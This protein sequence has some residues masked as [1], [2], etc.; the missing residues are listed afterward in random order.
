MIIR[1]AVEANLVQ[2]DT[3]AEHLGPYALRYGVRRAGDGEALLEKLL[4]E[5]GISTA[6]LAHRPAPPRV[7]NALALLQHSP[8]ALA[9]LSRRNADVDATLHA[10]AALTATQNNVLAAGLKPLLDA[11][12][13]RQNIAAAV[14]GSNLLKTLE[15]LENQGQPA[16]DALARQIALQG[17]GL[18]GLDA[19]AKA[20]E[21]VGDDDDH[22]AAASAHT[23]ELPGLAEGQGEEQGEGDRRER[24]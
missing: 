6:E 5:I 2:L 11:L 24:R 10:L 23:E 17:A 12:T 3:L 18:A 4:A 7:E 14:F 22:A 15:A 19:D 13:T 8:A 1:Q 9:A 16:F 21:A 20:D